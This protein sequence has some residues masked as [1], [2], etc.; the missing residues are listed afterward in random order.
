[1]QQKTE[2]NG[3]FDIVQEPFNMLPVR[4]CWF[5]HELS[6]TIECK[7]QVWTSEREVLERANG[8]FV[9]SGITTS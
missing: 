5:M 9:F 6:K 7:T 2:I 1:M 8:V 3:L 4:Y